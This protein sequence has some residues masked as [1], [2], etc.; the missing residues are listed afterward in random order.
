MQ[1]FDPDTPCSHHQFSAWIKPRS[2]ANREKSFTLMTDP[3]HFLLLHG[4]SAVYYRSMEKWE[5]FDT[6]W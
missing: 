1:Q 4:L 2:A 3:Q 5:C 6:K